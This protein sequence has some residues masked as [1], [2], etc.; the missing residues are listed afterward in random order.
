MNSHDIYL[1]SPQIAM[2]ILAAVIVV[3]DLFINDKRLVSATAIL[4]LAAPLTLTLILWFDAPDDNIG[5]FGALVVDKFALF[6]QV[7]FV[8]VG[9]LVLLAG[10]KYQERF[11]GFRGEFVA[12]MLFSLTGMMLLASA[13][14]LI[15][16]YVALELISLPAAALIAWLR[17]DRSSEAG[18]KFLL[19][20]AISSALLL[21]GLVFIYGFTGSTFF[22][23]IVARI[24][25]MQATG[26]L[27][28]DEPFGSYALMFGIVLLML[29]L[30]FKLSAVP[31]QM[32]VPDIYEGSPTP[33]AAF[34]SVAS[35]AA[36]FAIVLRL[37]Y[38]A[39]PDAQVSMDTGNLFA[40][41][42]AASMTVGNLLAIRQTNIKR[43]L[44]YST[45]AQ[46]GYIMVGVAAVAASSEGGGNASGG[47]QGVLFYLM[48]YG[49]TNLAV[50][51]AIIAITN[52]TG[53]DMISGFAGMAKRSPLFAGLLTI[54]LLSL[55]GFPPTVGFMGKAFIFSSAVNSGLL[56]LAVVGMVNSAASAYYYLRIVRTMYLD[57]ADDEEKIRGDIPVTLSTGLTATGV[58]VLG[59]APWFLLK[60]AE[61]AV[62]SL[63]IG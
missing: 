6:F 22:S 34:L 62:E 32:W 41:L 3:I 49:F 24:A 47:P 33:V 55:L 7:L 20:S 5:L 38:A 35:K 26:V 10:T 57:D 53:N 63:A 19:M 2:A 40:V 16:M 50:F 11:E 9:A 59:V 1:I 4:G 61:V 45:I 18:L 12:L 21:F 56:W 48:G 27:S 60:F 36:G 28:A 17:D 54:G 37:I 58:I 39:L 42:A 29:G 44:G 30:A 13:R 8:G 14:E 46:A 31:S 23:E 43:L 25:D 51:F 15:T 52:R